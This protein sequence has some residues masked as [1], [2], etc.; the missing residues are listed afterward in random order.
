MSIGFLMRSFV[1]AREAAC[2]RTLANQLRAWLLLLCWVLS[3]PAVARTLE[4]GPARTLTTPEQAAVEARDGDRIVFDPGIYP[5]CAIWTAS[6]L[7]IETRRLPAGMNQTIM[8]QVIVTGPVCADRG[9]FVFLGNN[10]TVRGISFQHARNSYHT[11]AGILMEG[12]NLTVDNA[13]FLNNENGILA[14]GPEYSVVRIRHAFFRG[15]GS[16]EGSCAHAVYAGKRIAQLE[17]E[18]CTFLDTRVG[19]SIKSRA[20]STVVRDSRIEDGPTGTSSYLIELPDGGDGE[21]V[22]NTL[23]KGALSQN[24]DAAISIGIEDQRDPTHV[25]TIRGNRFTNDLPQPVRFV[26]NSTQ[27][28]ARLSGN[29]LIGPVI[30]LEGP[31]SVTPAGQ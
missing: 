8:F 20:L 22:N 25:L 7:T 3:P 12:A 27:T 24:K 2:K 17:V 16:C 15:N 21:I 19:H 14:G 29:T 9:L 4:V 23:E 26:R 10:I 31:G 5:D 18:G 6:G 30:P 1:A 28:P 13:N 11:G